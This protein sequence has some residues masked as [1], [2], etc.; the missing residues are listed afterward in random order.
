V[1]PHVVRADTE[2]KR[3]FYLGFVEQFEQPRHPFTGASVGVDIDA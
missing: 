3:R 2:E 1:A